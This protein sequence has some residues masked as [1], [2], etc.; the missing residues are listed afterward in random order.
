MPSFWDSREG[1]AAFLLEWLRAQMDRRHVWLRSHEVLDRDQATQGT[2]GRQDK[3][4]T[5]ALE[6]TWLSPQL[7]ERRDDAREAG[8]NLR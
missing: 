4:G 2:T 6:A 8:A 5:W 1:W 3:P 7:Y